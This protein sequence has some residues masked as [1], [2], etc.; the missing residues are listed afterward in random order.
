MSRYTPKAEECLLWCVIQAQGADVG[1]V[2]LERAAGSD[3]ANLGILLG[4]PELF[5]R[6]IGKRAI[7]LAIA[8]AC[9]RAPL[10]VVRLHVRDD[11]ARAITCYERCGFCIVGSG[12]RE[13]G[14]RRYR[15]FGME[16]RLDGESA[17]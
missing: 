1:T 13:A 9:R 17:T 7:E 12:V 11:N 10:R 3:E 2:W 5:G 6:G 8:K 14:G 15:F 16:K 4:D